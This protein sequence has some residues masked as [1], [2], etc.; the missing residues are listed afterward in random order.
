MMLIIINNMSS[1]DYD[2]YS[3]DDV[4]LPLFPRRYD[5]DASHDVNNNKQKHM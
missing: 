2:Y 1:D 3:C 5:N 4:V